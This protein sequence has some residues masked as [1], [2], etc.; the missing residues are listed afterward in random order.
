MASL[1]V[2][3]DYG[4]LYN[5]PNAADALGHAKLPESALILAHIAA[6]LRD[7]DVV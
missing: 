2:S 4:Y 5:K 3:A 6:N 1:T 7:R